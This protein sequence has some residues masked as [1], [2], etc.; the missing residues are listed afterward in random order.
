LVE[1]S[2]Q[3]GVSTRALQMHFEK[4]GSV[5][6]AKAAELAAAVKE[7]VFSDELEDKDLTVRRA[8]AAR[9]AGYSNAVLVESLIISQLQLAM[10]DPAH[11]LRAGS[12]I[13]MLHL[14]AGA[15]ERLHDLK[16]RSLGLDRDSVFQDE[17]PVL[18]IEDLTREEIEKMRAER[19]EADDGLLDLAEDGGD[20]MEA[21]AIVTED[22]DD[23]PR[24]RSP[25]PVPV[26]S[27]GVRLVRG[28]AP[29]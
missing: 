3:F 8:K 22:S 13:K 29:G 11:A 6:G 16:W 7:Q 15:L 14:A 19:D 18:R 1:L 26:D 27:E 2:E 21:D 28:A 25:P 9:E 5:K 12:V 24:R 10:K 17:L 20:D 23:T 4:H